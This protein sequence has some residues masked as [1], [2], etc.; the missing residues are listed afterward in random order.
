MGDV[1]DEGYSHDSQIFSLGDWYYLHKYYESLSI[2]WGKNLFLQSRVM[3]SS[4][5]LLIF[6]NFRHSHWTALTLPLLLEGS[7]M[8]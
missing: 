3:I 2:A 7:N 4:L 1:E 8:V 5:F 6:I